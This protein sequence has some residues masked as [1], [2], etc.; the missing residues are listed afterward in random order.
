MSKNSEE[1]D[2]WFIVIVMDI[3]AIAFLVYAITVAVTWVIAHYMLCLFILAL[4]ILVT[5][6]LLDPKWY[7]GK[8]KGP[9]IDPLF[10]KA[11]RFAVR[12]QLS[13]TRS[14][15]VDSL[16]SRVV[17]KKLRNIHRADGLFVE[18]ACAGILNTDNGVLYGVQIS[19]RWRLKK[20]FKQINAN[21]HFFS[22][23]I[24]RRTAAV[25]SSLEY[26]ALGAGNDTDKAIITFLCYRNSIDIA[27]GFFSYWLA[28]FPPES[29]SDKKALK[30]YLVK[31]EENY[32]RV[33]LIE[34]IEAISALKDS[35]RWLNTTIDDVS[36][37]SV[38]LKGLSINGSSFNIPVIKLKE[39]ELYLLPSFAVLFKDKFFTGQEVRIVHYR[40]IEVSV[41]YY[42]RDAGYFNTKGME[43]EWRWKH[44]RVDGGPD[45]RYNENEKIYSYKFFRVEIPQLGIDL[46]FRLRSQ[47]SGLLFDFETLRALSGN[48]ISYRIIR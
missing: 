2:V 3:V 6:L 19:N 16:S 14:E 26:Q 25:K 40:N 13:G 17:P 34:R 45:R 28:C 42:T 7:I 36:I 20:V 8:P 30:E 18:L 10:Y 47:A 9:E 41:K 38:N 37:N 22:E 29:D 44:Q 4:I 35:I 39:W 24:Q 27:C 33:D 31:A 5:Y 21:S 46:D 32:P 48:G 12:K 43:Y 11:A 1:I 15:I 23:A